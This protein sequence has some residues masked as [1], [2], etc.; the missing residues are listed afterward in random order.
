M[1]ARR[2]SAYLVAVLAVAA[3]G[4]P[5]KRDLDLASSSA[6]DSAQRAPMTTVSSRIDLELTRNE[7]ASIEPL[8]V[9]ATLLSAEKVRIEHKGGIGHQDR[10]VIRF[11]KDGQPARDVTFGAGSR[12]VKLFGHEMAV[13]G[14]TV[15]SIFPPGQPAMP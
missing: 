12:V 11:E 3:C 14:G 5:E 7:P 13:F 9:T 15:L 1:Q 10:V 2:G 8:G 6:E 4:N